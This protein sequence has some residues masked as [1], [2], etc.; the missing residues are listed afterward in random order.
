MEWKTKWCNLSCVEIVQRCRCPQS[1][2][3]FHVAGASG[4]PWF[5]AQVRISSGEQLTSALV[6]VIFFFAN[7]LG[8]NMIGSR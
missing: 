5:I 2:F 1:P 4:L 7:C 3:Q 8:I 6:G